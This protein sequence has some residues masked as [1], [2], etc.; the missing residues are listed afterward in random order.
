MVANRTASPPPAAHADTPPPRRRRR[1]ASYRRIG[2]CLSPQQDI[3]GKAINLACLLAADRGASITAI[4]AVEVPFEFSLDAPAAAAET[5]ARE[6]VWAAHT[7]A[8]A[9][10][11]S[12]D[13]VVL[14]ARD[15][16]EAI[17]AEIAKRRAEIVILAGDWPRPQ[18]TRRLLPDTKA[19]VLKHAPCRVLLVGRPAASAKA[20]N[21]DAVVFRAGGEADYWPTGEFVDRSDGATSL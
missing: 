12:L 7:V 21:G 15:A 5:A 11:I 14:R 4:A 10:G 1:G 17:V 18:R 8:D 9:Y 16:G 3:A 19:H 6:A 20:Q 2:V 13:G